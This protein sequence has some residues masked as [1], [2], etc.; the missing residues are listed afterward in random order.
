MSLFNLGQ[1]HAANGKG[2]ASTHGMPYQ[3]A[4][5]YNAGYNSGK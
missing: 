3:A 1:N 4:N 5:Q 2:P